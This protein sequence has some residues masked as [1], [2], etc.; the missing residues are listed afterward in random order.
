VSLYEVQTLECQGRPVTEYRSDPEPDD[1]REPLITIEFR[2]PSAHIAQPLYIFGDRVSIGGDEFEVIAMEL[3]P[4]GW[5]YG[6]RPERGTGELIW[7]TE[8]E[9]FPPLDKE[10]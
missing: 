5:L 10:F 8:S 4:A 1:D 9:L 3:A 2:P 6:I 7:F